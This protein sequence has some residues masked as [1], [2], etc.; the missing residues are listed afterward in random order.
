[1]E[2]EGADPLPELKPFFAR[3]GGKIFIIWL[4]MTA[5]GVLIGIYAPHHLLPTMLSDQ[6]TKVWQTMVVFTVLAAPVAAFVYA[7][8]LYSLMG[9]KAR[10]FGKSEA[11][12]PDGPP[13]RGDAPMT[14]LWLGVSAAL[15][16][17]LLVWGLGEF[18]AEQTTHPDT[19]QVNVTGQQ[20]LWT[21]SYPG[22][23]NVKTRSLVLP[24]NRP[25]QFNVTSV[26]VT[27]G[28]W[29]AALGVQVDANPN[30]VTVIQ[31]TPDKVGGFTVRC[32]QLCG[33]YHSVMFASGS[34]VTPQKFAAWLQGQ[35]A[36]AD[37]AAEAAG[38]AVSK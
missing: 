20:W 38:V 1:M 37:E 12:P 14:A 2:A 17:V 33:L 15:V 28:F 11:P 34:V 18:T 36:S 35:G 10:G 13:L 23:G 6:G 32:S 31:A 30:T 25:V 21:F 19:L 29:P 26:D 27:H 16:I 9:W 5:V 22:A 24:V 8:G 3:A 4:A 7:V